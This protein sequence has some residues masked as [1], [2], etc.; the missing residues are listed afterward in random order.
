MSSRVRPEILK[1]GR[2]EL[3]LCGGVLRYPDREISLTP[4]EVDL[5]AYLIERPSREVSR[6]E[7]LA[8][9]WGYASAAR[10]RTVDALIC[11]L[12]E[13][14]DEPKKRPRH[15]VTV[16]RGYR[17]FLSPPDGR[18]VL[19]ASLRELLASGVIAT[20]VGPE[21]A[22]KTEIARHLAH[23]LDASWLDASGAGGVERALG[24][25]AHIDDLDPIR[26]LVLDGVEQISDKERDLV[27]AIAPR[28]SLLSTARSPL[29][30][31]GEKI[32]LIEPRDHDERKGLPSARRPVELRAELRE[33]LVYA[34][35]FRGPF[36]P[37]SLSA[38]AGLDVSS[39]IDALLAGGFLRRHG[40][41][42]VVL[43]EPVRALQLEPL[44][45]FAEERYRRALA[46]RAREGYW[47][48]YHLR[49]EIE[50]LRA[51]LDASLACGASDDAV[52]LVRAILRVGALDWDHTARHNPARQALA[53]FEHPRLWI[54]A[55]QWEH[56]RSNTPEALRCAERA[57]ALATTAFER[58]EID[59]LFG[60]LEI[61]RGR[62][63]D[64]C[65]RLES[66]QRA[67][68]A[69][70]ERSAESF[71]W[72]MLA[73]ARSERDDIPGADTAMAAARG[74]VSGPSLY[75][76]S[77][78]ELLSASLDRKAGRE[79]SAAAALRRLVERSVSLGDSSGVLHAQLL[80]MDVLLCV[81]D[82]EGA[83]KVIQDAMPRA[84]QS[85]SVV[86]SMRLLCNLAELHLVTEQP[87][88]A[89]L[90]ARDAQRLAY[91]IHHKG[92]RLNCAGLLGLALL[93]S[94]EIPSA[95]DV[96]EPVASQGRGDDGARHKATL[97]VA[98]AL[99]GEASAEDLLRS[100]EAGALLPETTRWIAWCRS[101]LFRG[102][103]PA[104]STTLT[105]RLGGA[106]VER[107]R[108]GQ[109]AAR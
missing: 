13:K 46:S 4:L 24:E 9:V 45:A 61:W 89:V 78:I 17:L 70:D 90:A 35:I 49:P 12:R 48:P 82:I 30:L 98:R 107:A 39:E 84:S 94:G 32:L 40:P 50:D 73:L 99:A 27:R 66:A 104:P 64:A 34:A 7:L 65:A 79:Q 58:A 10:T 43:P 55:A 68:E 88:L 42:H 76:R 3:D 92:V 6:V 37:A 19:C 5:L 21:G 83:S 106:L 97:S 95:I 85:N 105:D 75:L 71:A 74:G 59:L 2:A 22:G 28:V 86:S 23:Q 102:E 47:E 44:G 1:L 41:D 38:V 103:A 54:A 81:G 72:S 8:N 62:P 16:A 14:L 101:A 36:V 15:L 20:L 56:A 26:L 18:E 87:E 51:A 109:R 80:L 108:S 93:L 25:V 31:T 53:R 69:L 63:A 29:G 91:H 33:I 67:F 100:A 11:R 96:L 52:D 77:H 57:S 60:T